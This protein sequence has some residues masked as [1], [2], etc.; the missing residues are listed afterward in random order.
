[1]CCYTSIVSTSTTHKY[2]VDLRA[3]EKTEQGTWFVPAPP[4]RSPKNERADPEQ[5]MGSKRLRTEQIATI[6]GIAGVRRPFSSSPFLAH[7]KQDCTPVRNANMTAQLL[8]L[9]NKPD[10][11]ITKKAEWT[12]PPEFEVCCI[13]LCFNSLTAL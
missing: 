13:C 2:D 6:L 12:A 10:E 9:E 1:M 3:D 4:P 7:D 5:F 11:G 8:A